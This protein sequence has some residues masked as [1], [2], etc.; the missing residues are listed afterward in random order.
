MHAEFFESSTKNG[1]YKLIVEDKILYKLQ[2]CN[3]NNSNCNASSVFRVGFYTIISYGDIRNKIKVAMANQLN[4]LILDDVKIALVSK[5]CPYC[6]V[7]YV[8]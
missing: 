4:V 7:C 5:I 3:V 6:K 2:N 8:S 1:M